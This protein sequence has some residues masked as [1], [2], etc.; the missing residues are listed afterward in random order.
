[1]AGPDDLRARI[2]A[3]RLYQ[4]LGIGLERVA[5]G[6]VVAVMTADERHCN[7]DGVV[8]GGMYG[9]LADTAMGCAVRTLQ[10]TE[11]QN[12]TLS[13]A[14]DFLDGA[15]AGELLR[16]AAMVVHHVGRLAWAEADLVAGDRLIG[17]AR[18]LNYE[19][20]GA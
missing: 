2:A 9:L 20:R 19:V 17:R 12:K 18:S 13:L 10:A 5:P 6:D 4:D 16:A 8:Q 15:V 1:M 11:S 14:V 3:T 7:I